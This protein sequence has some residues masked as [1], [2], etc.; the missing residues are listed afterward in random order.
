MTRLRLALTILLF[1]LVCGGGAW[2]DEP[3][4][5]AS[6]AVRSF[7]EDCVASRAQPGGN[8]A[9]KNAAT[10]A[11]LRR[12][13]DI[14]VIS[15]ALLGRWWH[16]MSP[17]Q[18]DRFLSLF[19]GYVV[20]TFDFDDVAANIET[21]GVSRE[22]GHIVVNTRKPESVGDATLLD[23][24]V[25]DGQPPRIVDLVVDGLS[26]VKTTSGDF[27]AVLRGNGGDIDAFLVKLTEKVKTLEGAP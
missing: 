25:E 7:I 2:A 23:W 11:V 21:L 3:E 26:M 13:L 27:T 14:P 19:D 12:S 10:R 16:K 1:G 4:L 9:K 24:V 20:A 8:D 17:T 18:Q 5:L 6:K 22:G 15:Q